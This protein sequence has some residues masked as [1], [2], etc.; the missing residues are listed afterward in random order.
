MT[1]DLSSLIA[2]LRT[3]PVPEAKGLPTVCVLCS[4]NCGL[5]VDVEGDRIVKVRGDE[6]NVYSHGYMC[7]KAASIPKYVDHDQRATRP[8]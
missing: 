6:A 8:L 3:P 2:D 7:N 4:A 1:A 5:Q